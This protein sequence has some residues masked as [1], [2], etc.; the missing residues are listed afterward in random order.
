MELLLNL[1]WILI[2]GIALW[3]FVG[4]PKK[5]SVCSGCAIL[6]RPSSFPGNFRFR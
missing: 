1:V 3:S 6:R 2:G 4:Y 5:V